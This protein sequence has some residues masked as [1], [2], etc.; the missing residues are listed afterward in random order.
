MDARNTRGFSLIEMMIVVAIIVILTVLALPNFASWIQNSNIRVVAESMQNGL[1]FAQGEA[2]RLN[3]IT[4]FTPSGTGWTVSYMQIKGADPGTGSSTLQTQPDLYSSSV[5]V[6]EAA[7][8][9]AAAISFNGL[10]RVGSVG[11]FNATTGSTPFTL[12]TTDPAV[13]YQITNS[14]TSKSRQWN[15]TV[16]T[17][18]KIRMCDPNAPTFN[19]NTSPDGC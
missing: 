2:V 1:R 6:S 9:T 8:A 18:G 14:S 13:T 5:L 7:P 10:G 19:V 17:G 4:T 12:S 3:R 16:S 11:T 15:V